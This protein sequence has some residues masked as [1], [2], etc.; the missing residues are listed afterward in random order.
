MRVGAFELSDPLPELREPHVLATL[1]P[2]VDVGDVG[3]MTLARLQSHFQATELGRLVRPGH[4][5]D[6]TRYRPTLYLAEGQREIDVPNTIVF[7]ARVPDGPND[8]LFLSMLEPHMGSEA[9]VDSVVKLLVRFGVKRYSLVG[10]MYDTVPYTRPLPVSGRGSNI[11]LFNEIEAVNVRQSDYVG[12]TTI[13]YLISRRAAD[14]DVETLSL[15]VH[16]PNYLTMDN[17][18]RGVARL[19]HV[20]SKLYGFSVPQED[21]D[22]AKEQEDSVGQMAEEIM[23]QEPRYRELL[24]Q[25]ETNYDSRFVNQEKQT[26]LSPELEQLLQD[27]GKGFSQG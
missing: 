18:Y 2:W 1:R 21:L 17:D 6:F 13:L 22:K 27:L 10:S 15:L 20:L 25:L 9:Y 4:F 3:T 23:R 8:F 14:L 7:F 19:L 16:L 11:K 12:P 26:R 5:F 24:R